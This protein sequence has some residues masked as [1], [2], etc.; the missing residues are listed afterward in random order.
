MKCPFCMR[1][2]NVGASVCSACGATYLYEKSFSLGRAL[3]WLFLLIPWVG[4]IAAFWGNMF[5]RP[6]HPPEAYFQAWLGLGIFIALCPVLYKL[7]T[8][9]YRYQ[10]VRRI[11]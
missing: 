10:W 5:V 6:D 1:K 4:G 11:G 2:I 9:A 8:G 3:L 7:Y